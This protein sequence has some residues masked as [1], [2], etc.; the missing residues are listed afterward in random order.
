VG[1]LGADGRAFGGSFELQLDTPKAA[2]SPS[3]ITV[4]AT[5]NGVQNFTLF[6]SFDIT[7]SKPTF[8]QT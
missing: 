8:Y 4:H 1:R 7:N 2:S 5:R 6:T 3:E